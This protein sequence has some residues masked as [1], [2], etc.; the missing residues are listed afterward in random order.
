VIEWAIVGA[1]IGT[2]LGAM[3]I[4]VLDAGWDHTRPRPRRDSARADATPPPPPA[5]EQRRR[6]A[7]PYDQYELPPRLLRDLMAQSWRDF[8][9]EL[10][11]TEERV[12]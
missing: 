2:A 4:L 7:P 1:I 3:V 5:V 9:D 12:A 6:P 11:E 8:L 10:P